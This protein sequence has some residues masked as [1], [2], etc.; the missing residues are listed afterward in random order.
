LRSEGHAVLIVLFPRVSHAVYFDSSRNF[1]RKDYTKVM[2]LLDSALQGFGMRGGHIEKKSRRK[3]APCFSH[4]TNFCSIH[5]PEG[6]TNDGYYVI[7]LMMEFRKDQQRLRMASKDDNHIMIWAKNLAEPDY[8]VRDDF[9]RILKDIATI[10]MK[11]VVDKKGMFYHG[12]I[13]RADV[14]TRVGM[15]LLDITPFNKL[16]CVLPDMDGWKF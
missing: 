9:F 14:K 13:S 10:I 16:G 12:P 2:S 15:Q 7:H 4:K 8:K 11:E 5:Q 1:K 6:S 3:G